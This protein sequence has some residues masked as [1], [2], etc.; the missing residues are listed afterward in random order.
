MPE[1]EYLTAYPGLPNLLLSCK[2]YL[3]GLLAPHPVGRR[4]H[5]AALTTARDLH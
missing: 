5:L 1:P 2:I 4:R 3:R